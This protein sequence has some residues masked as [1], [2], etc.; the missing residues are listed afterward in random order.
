[1]AARRLAA[2]APPLAAARRGISS[3]ATA[4][5]AAAAASSS[6]ASAPRVLAPPRARAPALAPRGAR[7]CAPLAALHTCAFAG[8]APP[9]AADDLPSAPPNAVSAEDVIRDEFAHMTGS[10]VDGQARIDTPSFG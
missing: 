9:R 10:D 2:L 7:G 3:A 8:F 5:A 1:M 4:S 6:A